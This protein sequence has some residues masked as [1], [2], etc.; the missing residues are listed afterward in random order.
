M[1]VENVTTIIQK[2]I[3]FGWFRI[4]C[5]YN[6]SNWL[7]FITFNKNFFIIKWNCGNF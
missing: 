7:F 4:I 2:S 3:L 5:K 1:L 6:W